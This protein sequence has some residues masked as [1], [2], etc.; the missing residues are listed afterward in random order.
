MSSRGAPWK[1]LAAL[2]AAALALR[3]AASV[4]VPD[5]AYLDAA[6]YEL[7]AR[8]LAAG[9]GFSVPVVWSFLETGGV[10]PPEPML[11]VPSNRHWMP[12]TAILSAGSMSLIGATR[13]AAELPHA[14]LGALLVPATGWIGWWLWSS[15]RVALFAGVLA[16]FAG[17]MLVYVPMVDSF[18]LFGVAGAAAIAASIRATA[19]GAGGGWL[20]VSGVAVGLATLTRVDGVLLAVAPAIAWLARRG[21]GPW[22]VEGPAI[23]IGWAAAGAA[24]CALV[25][26][27]WLARQVAEFGSALPSAGG[28]LLWIASYNEQFS[29][30]G[31]PT[32][33]SYLASGPAVVVGARLDTLVQLLGRTSVVLGG[34]F[35]VPFLFGLWRERRRPELAPFI[36]YWVV[37]FAAMVLV[38]TFHAPA[39]A[40]YHSAWAWLPFAIPLAVANGLPL[41]D[42]LGRRAPMLRRPRNV[43]F[44]AG[45]ALVGA[46]VLSLIGSASLAAGWRRDS[47]KVAAAAAYLSVHA[48]ASDVV[49]Y[50][51]PPS[52]NLLTANPAVAPPFEQPAVVGEVARAYDVRWLVVER[53]TGAARDVLD[54]WEGAAWLGDAPAFEDGDIRIFAVD[55]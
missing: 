51:D 9:D 8:R 5:P 43:R 3:V 49:M 37:L 46:V 14:I 53:A 52:L 45:A 19:P 16:L 18:A 7:V 29:I 55:R 44:L 23:G 11:P 41:L 35:I 39:G 12:L 22:R 47:A 54:L 30:T 15:R 38:F 4:I 27:P 10:L 17:P 33:G 1:A 21:M 40:W 6:Y 13:F 48:S 31:D 25:L 36:V 20:I 50:V 26:A 42:A 34:A 32:L 24:A 28:R 2:G